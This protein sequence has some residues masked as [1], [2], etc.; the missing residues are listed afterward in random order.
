MSSD[1]DLIKNLVTLNKIAE[2]LNQ[3]RDTQSALDSA[4]VRLLELMG[5]KTGWIFLQDPGAQNR[6]AG[7]G[8][9]L[10][11]QHNLPPAMGL[12]KARAWKGGCDCQLMCQKGQLSGAYNEVRCSRL[13]NSSGDRRGLVMHA[14]TPLRSGDRVL[15]IL[16]V[17]GP[18]WSSFS[19]EALALL[20][21]VG[22]QMGI[23]LER[24]Q[25]FDLLQE[26][27]I[28]EQAA[29]LDLSSQL[30]SRSNLDDIMNYLV[31]QVRELL[32]ADACA[33]LLPATAPTALAFYAASG[34][35]F[36]PVAGQ[37]WTPAD[38]NSG[39]GLVMQTQQPLLVED[40]ALADP[41]PWTATWL[42]AEE[43]R[44]HAVVPLVVQ[45]NSIGAL[46]INSRFPRLLNEN[47]VR[48]L[49]L[50]A[51]QAAIA[52]EKARLHQEEIQR[53]RLEEEISV[54]RRIQLSLLPESCPMLP[55]WDFA[56]LYQPA[57]LVSGDL[58]DFFQLP[59]R[60]RRLG[61][62]IADVADKGV[63]AA[64][65]MAMSRSIIR[66]KALSG[67]NPADVLTRSNRLILRDGR[68]KLFLTAFYAI[69]HLH[70]NRLVYTS[71]GHNWPFWFRA[72]TGE[73]QEL[74]ARGIVLGVF[75][76]IQLEEHEIEVA[77]GDVL[78]FY[79]D[80]VTEAQNNAHELFGEARLREAIAANAAHSTAQQLLQA[81]VDAVERFTGNAP[82]SDDF[83]LFIVK[84]DRN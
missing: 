2:T 26:Q 4:L 31:H 60:P 11:A 21:N 44:G 34:W 27:R 17:A 52:I 51:N 58:Y 33:L 68:S 61:L 3:A 70:E 12:D 84:R 69:L 59:G 42:Q 72:A 82:Q 18:D 20:T 32:Q 54:G 41:T 81:V 10:A 80:G 38:A 30:L 50:M 39:P 73:I 76:Q 77:P 43:F 22:S 15:G 23:A 29:L 25:L 24:A 47:E 13:R 64:L 65:F 9:V 57:R 74:A 35:R 40:L 28:H 53:Q 63:P 14:S 46:V 48:F 5:L 45:G 6:W 1:N 7:K 71:A 36:D 56:A 67:R 49:C 75:E 62:L 8:Y 37:R 19:A 16:N 55:G 79:T 83:T 78:I 66:T